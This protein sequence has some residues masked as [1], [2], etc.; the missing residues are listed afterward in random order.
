[1]EAAASPPIR[2]H[3]N[4]ERFLG[5]RDDEGAQH[6]PTLPDTGAQVR[7]LEYLLHPLTPDQLHLDDSRAAHRGRELGP[8]HY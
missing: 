3:V 4:D 6:S 8:K 2:P 5:P 7:F 1:V